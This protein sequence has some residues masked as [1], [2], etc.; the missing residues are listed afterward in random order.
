MNGI[1]VWQRELANEENW[2]NTVLTEHQGFIQT[3]AFQ[4]HSQ[5]LASGGNDGGVLLWRDAQ[6]ISHTLNGLTAGTSCLDWHPSG[7]LL[8]GGGMDGTVLIWGLVGD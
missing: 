8:A 6:N 1:T 2:T 5:L 7:H 4:P 3:I